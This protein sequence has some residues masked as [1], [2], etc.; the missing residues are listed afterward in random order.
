MHEVMLDI[1]QRHR[2]KV[3]SFNMVGFELLQ[4]VLQIVVKYL[5]SHLTLEPRPL[6]EII[7][8][9]LLK[10]HEILILPC[11]FQSHKIIRNELLRL[12]LVEKLHVSYQIPTRLLG[13]FH[14]LELHHQDVLQLLEVLL[15][16]LDSDPSVRVKH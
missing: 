14:L 13:V 7:I 10:A 16:V 12:D 1:F 9:L 8:N 15:H 2:L 5:G 4:M 3:I 11:D 6:I